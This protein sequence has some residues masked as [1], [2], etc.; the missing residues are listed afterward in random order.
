MP[1]HHTSDNPPFCSL[2]LGHRAAD[3]GVGTINWRQMYGDNAFR[4]QQTVFQS[5]IDAA[6]KAKEI[7]Y[8]E[9]EMRAREYAEVRK[10]H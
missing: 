1:C 8:K 7:N 10:E 2:Q 3:C 4:M 5:D 6:K 9:L